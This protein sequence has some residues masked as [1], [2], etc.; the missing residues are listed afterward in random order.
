VRAACVLGHIRKE[1]LSSKLIILITVSEFSCLNIYPE[2]FVQN[3]TEEKYISI[4]FCY[5]LLNVLSL[6]YT[7]CWRLPETGAT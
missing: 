7:S 5:D 2:A 4:C 3:G 6:G 1:L